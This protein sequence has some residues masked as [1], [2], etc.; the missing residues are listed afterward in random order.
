MRWI[1]I[2]LIVLALIVVVIGGTV[3]FVLTLDPND[4]K[5]RIAGLVKHF[6]G[7]TL[8][9]DGRVDL[10]LGALTSLELTDARLGN[11]EWATEP[12]MA[13][14]AR[15][16]VVVDV[17][18]AVRGPIVIERLEL[19]DAELHLESLENDCNNWTFGTAVE[20]G[21]KDEQA[22][23]QSARDGGI[24]PLVLRRAE[25]QGLLF[26]LAIPALPR[27]LEIRAEQLMQEQ[28]DDG[29]LAATANGTLNER[30]ISVAGKYGPLGNLVGTTDVQFDVRGRFDTLSI[31]GRAMIDDLTWPRRP[32]IDLT[33]SGPAIDDVTDML[34]LPD[35]GDGGLDLEASVRPQP[36]GVEML[37]SGNI[38]EYVTDSRGRATELLD[39]EHFSITTSIRGPDLDRTMR[40]AGVE[41]V[42]GGAFEV[43]GSVARDGD[44]LEFDAVRLSIGSALIELNGSINDFRN[45]N[46]A[47]LNLQIDGTD[48]ER[49]RDLLGIPGAATGPFQVD[50]SLNV[51]PGGEELLEAFVQTNIA[52]LKLTGAI[53]GDAPEFVGTTLAF[54]GAGQNLADVAEVYEIPNVL[55]EPYSFKG[56]I[57]LGEQKL[58]TVEDLE[59]AVGQGTL[60][61]A[62]TVGYAP[63]E[64]DTDIDV[65]ATGQDLAKLVAM[66]GVTDLAPAVAFDI[67]AG[68]AVGA[69]GYRVRGLDATL[70]DNAITL[71]GTISKSKDFAGTR[72]TFSARGTNLGDVVADTEALD[73]ADGPFEVSGSA[74]LLT[75]AVRLQQVKAEVAGAAATLDAEIGLPLESA[76]GRFD[77]AASGPDLRAVVPVRPLWQPPKAP[78][79]LRA[80]GN[81]TDGLW[82]FDALQAQIADARLSGNGVFDQPPDLSRTRLTISMQV[83]D[84]AAL[85]DLNGRPLPSTNVS[86]D[87]G[88]AGS[89]QSFSV[90]P[91]AV[92]IGNGDIAGSLRAQLDGEVPDINLRLQ[93]RLLDLDALIANEQQL[94]G[95]S[96]DTETDAPTESAVE[97]PAN[98]RVIDDEPL[99]FEQLEKINARIDVDA[100]TLLLRGIEY[101]DVMIDG[102]IL[103][104]RLNLERAKAITPNGDLNF[105]LSVAPQ[106]GAAEIKAKLDGT[107]VNL[108]LDPQL[109]AEELANVPAFDVQ[110][111]LA[112]VGATAREITGTLGGRTFVSAYS[113]RFRNSSLRFLFGNFFS[114]LLSAVNPFVKEDP[115]TQLECMVVL[116]DIADGMIMVDPGLIAQTDK[117]VI[118]AKGQM[119]LVNEKLDIGFK[120]QP[121]SRVGISAG[122]FIN[123]YLKVGGTLAD[124]KLTLD[125][126]GTLV[127]GGAAVATAGLSLIATAVWDRV[128]RAEDPCAAALEEVQKDKSKRKK[129]LGIF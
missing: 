101:R 59:L 57:E 108:G 7:R 60:T 39:F 105:S 37:V 70:G 41:G 46:D 94:V 24:F 124:P 84:L 22:D 110:I 129:F 92:L 90:E 5:E 72:L 35:L 109:S 73:F 34:G 20:D 95:E 30:A 52:S 66:A 96:A 9:L 125:P 51:Q 48:V 106:N 18:S 69:D 43:D 83:P 65:R 21:G 93:S 128:F 32:T 86:I 91:F 115:Y 17:W 111:E 15:G 68:L 61:V 85:G 55:A 75:D 118:A 104:G 13:R 123:P 76:S 31:A 47:R 100:A 50:A 116:L 56:A 1:R 103:D 40:I 42:P 2:L 3:L 28:T 12:W 63:L 127:T 102:E 113:G 67:A 8:E 62:G 25:G 119:N 6:T 89:P 71:D 78:F 98:G 120:T 4:H 23:S 11:P 117:M 79:E 82:T 53:R 122:E 33:V 97:K 10:E 126:T 36:D 107:G 99:P 54:D 45:L 44:R 64:R 74:E 87:M 58:T 121:R 26:T 38:G 77:I 16:K 29:L 114:E 49:F 80:E 19:E 81:L 112:G 27:R 88:F 14:L